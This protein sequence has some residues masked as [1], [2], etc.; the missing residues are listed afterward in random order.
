M[1]QDTASAPIVPSGSNTMPRRYRLVL[2]LLLIRSILF[3]W[4]V[5]DSWWSD[6]LL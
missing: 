1:S 2:R 5:M 6:V 4:S 3:Q